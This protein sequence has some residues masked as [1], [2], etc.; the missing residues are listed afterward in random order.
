MIHLLSE[1]AKRDGL[2][3]MNQ[4]VIERFRDSQP[5]LVDV[6]LAKSVIPEINGKVLLHAGPPSSSRT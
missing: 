6:V 2:D 3:A 1:L 5:F 4:K